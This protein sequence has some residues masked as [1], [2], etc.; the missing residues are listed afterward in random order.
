[1]EFE[2]WWL[3]LL[4]MFFAAGWF[5]ARW[6]LRQTIQA[7][8]KLPATYFKGINHLLHDEQDQALESLID[9]VKL[10][11]DTPE[12][13]FALGALFRRRGETERAIRVH[14]NLI[15]R[16]DLPVQ[17]Q[18]QARLELGL[19]FIKAGL[20]SQAEDALK[21]LEGTPL[22]VTAEEQR[23]LLAQGVRNWPLAIQ[24]A[25]AL[26]AAGNASSAR[27]EVHYH[28]NMLDEFLGKQ[29][30]DAQAL[31][32]A[33]ATQANILLSNAQQCNSQHPRVL[34]S[35]IQVAK[36]RADDSLVVSATEELGRAH[37]TYLPLVLKDY[38]QASERLESTLPG[39]VKRAF[40]NV[41]LWWKEAA[42]QDFLFALISK[43]KVEPWSAWIQKAMIE[44]PSARFLNQWLAEHPDYQQESSATKLL[45]VVSEQLK[46]LNTKPARYACKSCGFQ[47]RTHYW[48]CP[49]C[50]HW[51]TYPPTTDA[52]RA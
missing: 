45:P 15:S 16:R 9:V 48:Q 33:D 13:H 24:M 51:E 23:I 39:F 1:M 34:L 30:L 22:A 46:L 2:T 28:C 43:Q 27:H 3:L 32:E 42:S 50:H 12:L 40:E 6:D 52:S 44:K 36:A 18:Q 41:Q 19:D 11:P 35:I 26:R 21:P 20:L 5:A 47:A 38:V 25:Q 29:A 8:R 4:P 10:D 49:G 17:Y 14:E 37:S 31:N 7:S